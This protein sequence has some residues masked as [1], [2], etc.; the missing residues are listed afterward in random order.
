MF[1]KKSARTIKGKTYNHY[2]IVESYRENGTVKHRI[3]FNVGDLTD[4]QA[5]RL[6]L[7]LAA[8]SDNNI[9]VS[10]DED[11]VVTNHFAYLD[12]AVLFHLW[13]EWGFQQFFRADRWIKTLVF[14]RCVDPMAKIK[15]HDWM[16]QTVLPAYVESESFTYDEYDVY[17]ELDR[18]CKREKDIQ[19]FIYQQLKSRLP[20]WYEAFFYDITS[21]F[22]EGKRCVLAALGYS[23]DHRP[24][25]EQIVIALMITPEGYPFHWRVLE[26]NTQDVTTVQDL[27]QEV[28]DV[29]GIRQCIMVF[30]RGMVS[31]ENLKAIE[32]E[33]WLYVSAMDRDE[34]VA[35]GLLE[36]AL[37]QP[38]QPDDWESVMAMREFI[39]FDENGFLFFREFEQGNRRLILTFDVSR[40]LDERRL[41]FQRMEHVFDW[42]KQKNHILGKAKKSRNKGVLER[43]VQSL[44]K[45]KRVQKFLE[46]HI[47]PQS[48][49]ITSKNGK[50]RNVQSFH[51][52]Y[53]LDKEKLEK[54][55]RVHGIYCFISNLPKHHSTAQ[56]IIRWYRRKNKVEE[57]FHEIKSH[58]ELRPIYLSREERV[59][60]HVTV[61]ILA[62]FLYN[63]IE[64]RLRE[65]GIPMSSKDALAKLKKC[66][67]N[68]IS[69]KKM[70]QT[71]LSITEPSEDQKKLL[72]ALGCE[73]TIEQKHV[74]QVLK[75]MES[76]V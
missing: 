47:E 37:P 76:W 30:D 9:I 63:D 1:L 15:L 65:I 19:S 44:L 51:L 28:K 70:N 14:N 31:Y 72:C 45:R 66:Q 8:H 6:R 60:A 16:F 33:E 11:I 3:L 10:K 61:C 68:Q 5:E 41:Q 26:G 69:F 48:L 62:Y 75:K 22:M 53:S 55:Q 59:K 27:V 35:S 17:R 67:V 20:N 46:I 64:R 2:K 24:D 29:Y 52:S 23:R 36:I 73:K 57:A 74:R 71:K 34:L 54:E 18:L 13:Q 56:E 32:S 49:T 42:V 38:A 43:E 4:E 7:A 39:P 40:F 12:I 25:C 58:M 50:Q 21:T